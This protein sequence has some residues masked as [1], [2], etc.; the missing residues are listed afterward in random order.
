MLVESLPNRKSLGG[1]KH[2]EEMDVRVRRNHRGKQQ[3]KHALM[4]GKLCDFTIWNL[5]AIYP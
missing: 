1:M 4:Q 5:I 2:R 3:I